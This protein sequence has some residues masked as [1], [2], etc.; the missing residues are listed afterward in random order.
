MTVVDD[1]FAR[2][3]QKVFTEEMHQ[4]IAQ[5]V[6]TGGPTFVEQA[7]ACERHRQQVS[8]GPTFVEQALRE[9]K[10]TSETYSNPVLAKHFSKLLEAHG[11]RVP[12]PV[13]HN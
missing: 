10:T 2:T 6:E 7:T 3:R 1:V 9:W 8:G 11:R 5:A 4:L 12:K 13:V